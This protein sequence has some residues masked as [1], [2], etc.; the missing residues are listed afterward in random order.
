MTFTDLFSSI[1]D[2]RSYA[3]G[4][5][6]DT[7]YAQLMPS[8]RSAGAEI[9]KI[10]TAG[11][12]IA[13]SAGTAY[14]I[15]NE[16][17]E[18]TGDTIPETDIQEAKELLKTAVATRALYAYQ[19]FNTVKKNGSDASLYKYQ[20]E[21]I[22]DFYVDAYW[23]AV[24]LL[25]DWMDAHPEVGG[26]DRTTEYAQRQALPVRNAEEFHHYYGINRSSFFY[27]KVLFLIRD[28]WKKIRPKVAT[29]LDD[30]EVMD[31]A[32]RALCY[33]VIAHAVMQFDVT[34]LPRSIRWDYNHE[35]T[36]GSSPQDRE[37][38]YNALMSTVNAE[39]EAIQTAVRLSGG[40]LVGNSNV[41]SDK[42]YM[43]I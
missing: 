3:E 25:L 30:A 34:E 29:F 38:L 39:M 37:R 6:A 32:K 27:S 13:I 7:T 24:D 43:S 15:K 18:A 4:L 41:E 22:K 40:D 36:R 1:T 35:Y 19:I 23:K 2:F 9:I 31:H 17:G 16:R 28:C 11:A 26:Y 10:I 42:F 14:A 5:Q 21:E 8:I 33:M 20:H 12:Y